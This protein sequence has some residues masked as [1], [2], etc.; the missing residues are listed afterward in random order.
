M[1]GKELRDEEAQSLREYMEEAAK[2]A[3]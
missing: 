1:V 2:P 3:P